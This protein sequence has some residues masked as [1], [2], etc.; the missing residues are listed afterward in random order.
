MLLIDR[1]KKYITQPFPL[2]E[3]E[4]TEALV[5]NKWLELR[6]QGLKNQYEYST[7]R[8]VNDFSVPLETKV[9]ITEGNHDKA[10]FLE[11]ISLDS[12]Q[13]F[14]EEHGLVPL[15]N[16]EIETTD[17]LRKIQ[18]AMGFIDLVSPAHFS[19]INLVRAI[20]VLKQESEEFDLS[21]SHPH[22]PFTIFVSVCKDD[23]AIS[24]LRVAESILHEAM[25]L[26][27]TLIEEVVPLTFVDS[28]ILFYSPWRDQQR[29]VKG[30][31]HGLF[32][33]KAIEEFY[34]TLL[35]NPMLF[36]SKE[37]LS[38]RVTQIQNEIKLIEGFEASPGLTVA[39]ANLV[40]SLLP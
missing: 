2:W 12:F 6:N 26:K 20:Q 25:H 35:K 24:N 5:Q 31:I 18:C 34:I 40:I 38:E 28:E 37:Y 11:T 3:G 4:V 27:L 32:V 19:I 10:I 29:P 13:N 16:L 17:A 22:I 14:Y 15:S 33:F 23:S 36:E 9:Q 30:V 39:G 1:V 7:T 21:Y 8:F